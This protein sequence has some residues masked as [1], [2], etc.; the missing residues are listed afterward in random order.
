MRT[1]SLSQTWSD[2]VLLA[3]AVPPKHG[4][5]VIRRGNLTP[6]GKNGRHHK[7]VAGTK[8]SLF[9]GGLLETEVIFQMHFRNHQWRRANGNLPVHRQGAQGLGQLS[10][11]W[12]WGQLWRTT[13]PFIFLGIFSWQFLDLCLTSTHPLS[14]SLPSLSCLQLAKWSVLDPP[15]EFLFLCGFMFSIDQVISSRVSASKFVYQLKGMRL[16]RKLVKYMF[17][18]LSIWR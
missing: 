2:L 7:H 12:V 3:L 8:K 14:C 13:R 11:D 5:R 16:H 4:H 1:S 10:R 6:G 17:Q 15:S 18:N 9:W